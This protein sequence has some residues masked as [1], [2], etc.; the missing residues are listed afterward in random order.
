MLPELPLE[1]EAER[2]AVRLRLQQC[3]RL[4]GQH[5]QQIQAPEPK[6]DR[7]LMNLLSKHSEVLLC[8]LCC[9]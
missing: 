1:E 3:H 7:R 5:H 4:G 9:T 2:G 8:V 6:G